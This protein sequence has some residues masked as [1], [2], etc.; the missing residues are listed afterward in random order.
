VPC[1]AVPPGTALHRARAARN[2]GPGARRVS[3]SLRGR[4]FIEA[5]RNGGGTRSSATCRRPSGDGPSSRLVPLMRGLRVLVSPSL[6][7]R[8]F[9]EAGS[10]AILALSRR[11]RR[12]SG[13]GPS[14]RHLLLVAVDVGDLQSPSLRGRPFI[15]AS[16]TVLHPLRV[17]Q[18]AVPPGTALHRGFDHAQLANAVA[19]VAVPP[20]TALHRGLIDTGEAWKLQGRSPSLRGRPFIEASCEDR[21]RSSG[22]VAVPPGTA[23]HRGRTTPTMLIAPSAKVA[24]PPGTALHRGDYWVK[25]DRDGSIVSPSLRGRPFIEA[26]S[27]TTSSGTSWSRRPSGDG[28]SSRRRGSAR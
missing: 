21:G 27:R 23:L 12:P 18:V 3:P 15:E 11:R 10:V 16:I 8:P 25:N 14:S 26:R 20:G 4:P 22:S 9:I 17:E 6:R 5:R 2:T 7:G 13:D 1:V 28:P 24:V 19:A